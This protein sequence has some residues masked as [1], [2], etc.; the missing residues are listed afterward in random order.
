[1][2]SKPSFL[3]MPLELRHEIYSYLLTNK[4]IANIATQAMIQP[5]RNGLV[6]SCSQIFHEML[7]YYYAKNT[8][9]LS[10]LRPL[11]TSPKLLRHLGRVQHLQ[12]EVGDLGFSPRDRSFFLPFPTQERCNWFLRTLRLAKQVHQGHP[13]KTLVAVDRCGTSIVSE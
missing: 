1:M 5:L 2:S 9:L 4:A 11:E 6:R 10:L 13:F 7:D 12:V 3:S 8:F